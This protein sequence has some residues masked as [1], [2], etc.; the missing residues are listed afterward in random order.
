MPDIS[1]ILDARA[2]VWTAAIFTRR[3]RRAYDDRPADATA[4]TALGQLAEHFRP[5]DDARVAILPTSPEDMFTGLVGSYGRI[6]GAVSAMVFLGSG[7]ALGRDDHVG[8]VSAAL[9]LEATALGIATVWV[10]G[11]ID[12]KRALEL[13][14]LGADE[15]VLGAS[16]LGNPVA[17]TTA[18]G[19]PKREVPTLERRKPL[20]TLA[21]AMSAAWPAWARAAVEHAQWA[22]SAVNRAL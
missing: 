20:A 10:G 1:A 15:L 2:A 17:E 14:S 9:M 12:R 11:G 19:R 16:P 8:Y 4:L 21:P 22:P 6:T 13:T 5:Y 18:F 3:S 7:D